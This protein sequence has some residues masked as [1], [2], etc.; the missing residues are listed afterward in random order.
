MSDVNV[1]LTEEEATFL[2]RSLFELEGAYYKENRELIL[3]I[4]DKLYNTMYGNKDETV[5][6]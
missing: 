6:S 4:S 1:N 2:Y 5:R 3:N